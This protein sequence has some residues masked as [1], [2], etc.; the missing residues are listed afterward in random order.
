MDRVC[1]SS[2]TEGDVD[3][4]VAWHDPS[5][6]YRVEVRILDTSIDSICDVPWHYR[7]RVSGDV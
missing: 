2:K 7:K 3:I 1:H 5:F 6:L 4:L